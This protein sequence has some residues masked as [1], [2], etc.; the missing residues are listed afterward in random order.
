MP[1]LPD[2]RMLGYKRVREDYLDFF[3][4]TV[5]YIPLHVKYPELVDNPMELMRRRGHR[6]RMKRW[7]C[8]DDRR[9]LCSTGY[10]V[11]NYEYVR[12]FYSGEGHI[13]AVAFDPADIVCVPQDAR[14][15]KIR[16]CRLE[17]RHEISE[18]FVDMVFGIEP[19]SEVFT[20]TS[21][22]DDSDDEDW[23]DADFV[24]EAEDEDDDF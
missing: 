21:Y 20:P 10:H 14:A 3:S 16:V 9:N 6:I 7:Q 11:G 5:P 2:G 12:G 19:P 24:E 15:D 8:D 18:A 4:G 22:V 17:V 23:N 1:I 13:V